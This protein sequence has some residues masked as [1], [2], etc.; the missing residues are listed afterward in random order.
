MANQRVGRAGEDLAAQWYVREGFTVL[1]RN[2]RP[3][4]IGV[5][6]EIDLVVAQAGLVVFCEVK[7]RTSAFFGSPAEAVSFDRQRRLRQLGRAWLADRGE[8]FRTVRFDVVAIVVAA[9]ST[10]S[11]EVITAAF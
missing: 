10:P 1:D 3:S 2:W 5:R 4:G 7:T 11:I 6:G 9:R 8:S